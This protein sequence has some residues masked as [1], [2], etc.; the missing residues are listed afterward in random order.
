MKTFD[1]V[2]SEKYRQIAETGTGS[3]ET[4]WLTKNGKII[5]VLLSSTPFDPDNLSLGVTFHFPARQGSR[6]AN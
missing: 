3:V 6:F 4:L 1:I 5:H 2:G